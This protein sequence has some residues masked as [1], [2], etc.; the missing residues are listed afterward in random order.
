MP[1]SLIEVAD[2]DLLARGDR[3]DGVS[4]HAAKRESAQ[5]KQGGCDRSNADRAREG[6]VLTVRGERREDRA[7]GQI[8][9]HTEG[10]RQ[11]NRLSVSLFA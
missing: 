6:K 8:G 1:Q 11:R 3:P 10:A 4:A 2:A 7:Y 5:M 9:R